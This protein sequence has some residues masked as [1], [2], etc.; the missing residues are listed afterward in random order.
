MGFSTRPARNSPP[1]LV[2]PTAF[3]HFGLSGL[4]MSDSLSWRDGGS[5]DGAFAGAVWRPP[6]WK[7][8]GVL[9]RSSGRDGG[10]RGSGPA[11]RGE[12]GRGDPSDPLPAQPGGDGRGDGGRGG[13]A[14][15]GTL[16][17]PACPGDPGHHGRDLGG[18]RRPLSARG[19]GGG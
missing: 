15:G 11:A 3:T 10:T 6:A 5:G 4:A 2:G 17:R 19:F 14:D 18:R 16:R 1:P 9:A 7:K 12:P 8:G 13:G